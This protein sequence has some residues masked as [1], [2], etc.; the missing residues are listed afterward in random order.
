MGL[1]GGVGVTLDLDL[2]QSLPM[3]PNLV[4]MADFAT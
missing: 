1:G 3:H 4:S 2:E